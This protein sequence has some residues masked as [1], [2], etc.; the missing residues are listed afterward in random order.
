ML[1]WHKLLCCELNNKILIFVRCSYT[2]SSL[3]LL[4]MTRIDLCGHDVHSFNHLHEFD[5]LPSPLPPHLMVQQ[6]SLHV[7]RDHSDH[8]RSNEP[9]NPCPEWIHRFIWSTMVQVISDHWS[10]SGSFQRNTTIDFPI[11]SM[12]AF[13]WDDPDQDQWSDITR[14]LLHQMNWWILTQGRFIGSFDVLHVS[15]Q[16]SSPI[17]T[18]EPSLARTHERAVK[19]WGAEERL[20]R[21]LVHSR[22]T[23]FTRPNRRAFSQASY[24]YDLRTDPD[25]DH[26]NGT[27]PICFVFYL[28]FFAV[29]VLRSWL[30]Q[31]L[32]AQN[33]ELLPG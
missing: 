13:L 11:E 20:R 32:N 26:P 2:W 27:H 19:L 31:I 6:E 33:A 22:E 14:I 25:P 23:Y 29:T 1:Q 21:S 30:V 16:A 12:G 7:I 24:M 17:W 10:W 3:S 4:I 5:I 9:M 18:S 15:L 8:G 28:T